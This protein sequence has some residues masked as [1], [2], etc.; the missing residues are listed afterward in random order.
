MTYNL[1]ADYTIFV[2]EFKRTP[3]SLWIMKPVNGLQGKGIFI[4]NKLD[5]LKKWS[6]KGGNAP[7]YII[8]YYINNPLLIGGKKFDLRLY[9]LVTSYRPLRVYQY[10]H[11]FARYAAACNYA[12]TLPCLFTHH[13]HMQLGFAT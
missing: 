13:D 11:G 10:L 2:E 4:V 6:V 1:P 12:F 3:N 9:C 5:Q 8:S 7:N